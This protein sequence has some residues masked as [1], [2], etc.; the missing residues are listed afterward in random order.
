MIGNIRVSLD[1]I[2]HNARALRD[3][4]A[5]A[6]AAFVVKGNAYGHGIV[7]VARTVEPFAHRLC[8]YSIEEAAALR[9]AGIT[10]P[11]FVMGPVQSGDLDEARARKAEIALWD[12]GSY[13]R[14][15][16][17]SARK[18][19][20]R[21]PVHVKINTGTT[22]LG[23]EPHDA[24]DAI[25]DYLRI[26][27]IDLTGVFSHLAAAEELDSPFTLGQ[28]DT[29]NRALEP[30][31]E[32]LQNSSVHPIKHIAASA[33]AMLWPQ[34]RLDMVRIGIA[35]YG[36]WPSPQTRVAMNGAKFDLQPALSLHSA[37]A[38]VRGV[39]AG[40]PIGYGGSYHAP[41]RTRIGVVP[42]GYADGIPRLLS[43]RGAFLVGGE[44]CPIVGR[45]CMNM[46]MI[47]LAAAPAAKPGD[48]VTLIGRQGAGEVTADQWGEWAETI[49]YEIVTR[50]PA[51]LPRTYQPL[52]S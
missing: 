33:A 47:D 36:L 51:E 6:R 29:F 18:R 32:L 5:P 8:V 14:A 37:L 7:E 2:A 34:T 50:L 31:G 13:L 52:T 19:G 38:A 49:N 17:D 4:V 30:A 9:E 10:R 35:L 27:E 45:V 20:E 39:E 46:T 44:R 41:K 43:N 11:I 1:A 12:T 26:P 48:E 28:L 15:V 40:T 16:I 24:H 3:L 22:R 25:E 42:L 23:L 21:A